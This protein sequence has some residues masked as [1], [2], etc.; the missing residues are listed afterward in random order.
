M[1]IDPD[2]PQ[3]AILLDERGF[4]CEGSGVQLD[5][6]RKLRNAGVPLHVFRAAEQ[7][8]MAMDRRA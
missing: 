5:F 6:A 1:T 2:P 8:P 3:E 7:R 4:V